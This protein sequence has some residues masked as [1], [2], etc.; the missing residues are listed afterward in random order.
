LNL[1]RELPAD[2]QSPFYQSVE[3]PSRLSSPSALP[4]SHSF[5]RR[6]K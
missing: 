3:S 1:H 4:P 2:L 5:S 6:L